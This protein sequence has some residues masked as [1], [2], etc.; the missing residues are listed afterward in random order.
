MA[1]RTCAACGY[2]IASQVAEACPQCGA[3]VPPAGG[4]L[5][6]LVALAAFGVMVVGVLGFTTTRGPRAARSGDA[7]PAASPAPALDE[8]ACRSADPPP[9]EAERAGSLDTPD[10][11]RLL[12]SA[13]PDARRKAADALGTRERTVAPL[14]LAA[15]GD[16]CMYVRRAAA[17]SVGSVLARAHWVVAPTDDDL[18]D[19]PRAVAAL[20]A[21]LHDPFYGVRGSAA[22]ALGAIGDTAAFEALMGAMKDDGPGVREEAMGAL[23]RLRDERAV[24]ALLGELKDETVA[25]RASEALA[26]IDGP[27]VEEA[28]LAALGRHEY[29]VMAGAHEFYIRR[30]P[31]MDDA[32]LDLYRHQNDVAIRGAMAA[33]GHPRLARAA[34][35][36]VPA[37]PP[38]GGPAARA[39][40]AYLEA[41]QSRHRE[42]VLRLVAGVYA[43]AF[44]GADVN[45]LALAR[46]ARMDVVCG[47]VNGGE[48]VLVARGDIG[49]APARGRVE[50][51]DEKGWKVRAESWR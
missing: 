8:A 19:R 12:S 15:L 46:P 47:T 29:G 17:E 3:A 4:G 36:D 30:G 39:Y 48:V 11:V 21:A 6:R 40:A 35:F 14:L 9:P 16:P 38:D 44:A 25:W 18:P 28:L 42:S 22:G 1:E 27:R 10:L 24:P 33:S 2:R 41:I 51:V 13:H 37:L 5:W 7:P 32:V 50:M 49:G 20:S 26:E 43:P 31:E 45:R 34:D 23:G